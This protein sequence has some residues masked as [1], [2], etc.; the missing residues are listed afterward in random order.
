[1]EAATVTRG[2]PQER[3]R[4]QGMSEKRLAKVMVAPSIVLILIVAAWPIVY[5]IWLSLHQYSVR[6][7]GLSRWAGVKNYSDAIS[8]PEWR[9]ALA[10]TLI[11]TVSSVTL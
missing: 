9:A 4:S 7:A 2:A 1:M 3:R 11:F 6:V 8:S 10:H 5:A